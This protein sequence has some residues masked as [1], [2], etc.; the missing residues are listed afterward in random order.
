MRGEAKRRTS[1]QVRRASRNI[2]FQDTTPICQRHGEG[3][4]LRT[5]NKVPR[6]RLLAEVASSATKGGSC[7]VFGEVG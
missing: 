4:Y 6:S 1:K 3:I 2:S 5:Q 7:G